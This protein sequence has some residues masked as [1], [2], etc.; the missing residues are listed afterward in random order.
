MCRP[1]VSYNSVAL[2]DFLTFEGFRMFMQWRARLRECLVVPSLLAVALC[3]RI[4]DRA[5][6]AQFPL[7]YLVETMV[8]NLRWWLEPGLR[9]LVVK[10]FIKT[11]WTFG[12]SPWVWGALCGRFSRALGIW[13]LFEN[14]PEKTVRRGE[15]Q[16]RGRDLLPAQNR[17]L[18]L[19]PHRSASV[20]WDS[21]L[22]PTVVACDPIWDD[23]A[24]YGGGEQFGSSSMAPEHAVTKN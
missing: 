13:E 23:A 11:Q 15:Q 3:A 5:R 20:P 9:T 10:G 17:V 2:D 6:L 22:E 4:L 14:L 8:L 12:P 16:C 7:A 1:T 21:F 24:Q 18:F 19:F